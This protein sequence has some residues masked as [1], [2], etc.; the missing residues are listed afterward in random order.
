MPPVTYDT[1]VF[2]SYKPE[3]FPSGFL[4]SAIVSQELIASAN[5]DSGMS[6]WGA[7]Q[8]AFEKEDRLIVPTSADWLLASRVL[9][10]LMRRRKKKA[11]G[12]SPPLKTGASQRTPRV[13]DIHPMLG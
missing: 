2:K 9:Y 6:M 13:M 11:G 4:F 10:W 3:D 5:D 12:Q 7:T 1:S 8:R